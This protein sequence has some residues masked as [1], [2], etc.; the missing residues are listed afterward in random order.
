MSRTVFWLAIVVSVGAGGCGGGDSADEVVGSNHTQMALSAN[1]TSADTGESIT[2]TVVASNTQKVLTSSSIDFE[3]DGVWDQ[4]HSHNQ[5]SIVTTFTHSYPSAGTYTV[6]AEVVDA[7]QSPTT[8]TTTVAVN[9]PLSI[10]VSETMHGGSTTGPNAVCY[11]DAG[12]GST[13]MNGGTFT[14]QL[15]SY[16]HGASVSVT[17]SFSQDRLVSGTTGIHYSCSFDVRLLAGTPGSEAQFAQGGCTTTSFDPE[18]L[19]CSITVSGVV[20]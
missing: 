10:P 12:G 4:E 7:D 5:S 13:N 9:A 17:E 16:P 11:H 14:L 20:P 6:R 8:K 1:P 3:N 19:T 2:F 15:G 18:R